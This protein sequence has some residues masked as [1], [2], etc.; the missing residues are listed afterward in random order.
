MVPKNP[1]YFLTIAAERSVSKAAERLYLSQPYLSQYLARLEKE[2]GARLFD[3]SH[4]PL[5][6]TPAGELYRSYL[7]S[8][9]LLG[10]RLDS[11]LSELQEH[12]G[13]TLHIG[14]AIWRGSVLLPDILPRYTADH[15]EVRIV[16]HEHPS[17][18]LLELIQNDAIDF[19]VLHTP[20]DTREITYETI[21]HERLLL[22]AHRSNPVAAQFETSVEDPRPV[23]IRLFERERFILLQSSQIIARVVENL[24]QRYGMNVS[25]TIHTTS[26]TTAVN[27][28]GENFGLTFL[29]EAG[30][31]RAAG[32]SQL[33]FFTVDSPTLTIPLS[34]VYKKSAFISPAARA[35]IDLTYE[36]YS[37]YRKKS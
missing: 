28:V 2:L 25:H 34:I 8:V 16:L 21:F 3:R 30:I 10:R 26:S 31:R 6:L 23:D 1:E 37:C 7:E 12:K 14:V 9:S 11:Q 19:A 15:P 4:T 17:N 20:D 22:A 36:H 24:F 5:M 18:E 27:L 29:P 35:F 32:L 33:K 13:N